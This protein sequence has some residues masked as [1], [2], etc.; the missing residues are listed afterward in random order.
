MALGDLLFQFLVLLL[1]SRDPLTIVTPNRKNSDS[2]AGN[3]PPRHRAT[4]HWKAGQHD[5]CSRCR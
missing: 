3:Q 4:A 5:A 2:H 1:K